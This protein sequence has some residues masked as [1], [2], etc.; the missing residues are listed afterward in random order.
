[1]KRAKLLLRIGI[2]FTLVYAAVSSFLDP[3]AWGGFIP[4]WL[5]NLNPL[6]DEILLIGISIA[7]IVL[8]ALI[9][10][11]KRPYGASVLAAVFFAAVVVFNFGALDI[12]FRDIGLV[13]A[14]LALAVLSKR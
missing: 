4:V 9:L 5:N 12:L 14:A 13:F 10:F 2:A 6:G 1:M 3:V 8:A 7:E 11:Q